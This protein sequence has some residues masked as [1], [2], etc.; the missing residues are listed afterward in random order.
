[1][2]PIV[3]QHLNTILK[4]FSL[5][6]KHYQ[7]KPIT[8]GYIN[9]TY[10]VLDDAHPKFILQRINHTVFKDVNG[11][12]GNIEQALTL[13]Y[14]AAYEQVLL[15]TTNY[16]TTFHEQDGYWRVMSYIDHSTTFNTTDDPKIAYEAGKIIGK[17]H[18]LLATSNPENY[19]DT[20]PKFHDLDLRY[21]QLQSA[22]ANTDVE[23]R[24]SASAALN[25]A[26]IIYNALQPLTRAALPVRICHNDTKLNN[27]LFSKATKKALC[28][29]DL[30]TLMKGYFYYDFGDA[31]RTIVNPANEDEQ[32]FDKIGFDRNLF[33]AFLKGLQS[34]GSF[35]T[36]EEIDNLPLGMVFMPFIHG[37]RALTDYLENN[38]YYKVSYENQNLDRS[39][40]LFD[41]TQKAWNQMAFMK[42]M[43]QKELVPVS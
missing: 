4:C 29:I 16:G 3:E 42:E 12:M 13:L 6:K 25:F 20:I 27:I 17:F 11:L 36:K 18:Q 41:F 32:D 8:A 40:S 21:A 26:D 15:V 34:V 24:T 1:M 19:V 43:T 28:L 35:L 14:D 10:L 38:K 37:L 5:P 9:D 23:R 39:L 31:V 7:L 22:L 2:D 30:D 33:L